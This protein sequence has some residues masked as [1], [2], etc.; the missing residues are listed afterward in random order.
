MADAEKKVEQGGWSAN[1][2]ESLKKENDTLKKQLEE[3]SKTLKTTQEELGKLKGNS[4]NSWTESGTK[5]GTESGTESSKEELKLDKLYKWGKKWVEKQDVQDTFNVIGEPHK[6][7][8]REFINGGKIKEL[9]QYLNWLVD[10]G[11]IDGSEFKSAC[12]PKWIWLDAKNH[13]SVDWKFWPQTLEALRMLKGK[14]TETPTTETPTTTET[15]EMNLDTMEDKYANVSSKLDFSKSSCFKDWALAEDGSLKYS[16]ETYKKV[17]SGD[18]S[19]EW[20]GYAVEKG[21]AGTKLVYVWVFKNGKLSE[22]I[23]VDSQGY[24]CIGKFDGNNVSW[25][26]TYPDSSKYKEY[27]WEYVF[28]KGPH[29]KWKLIYRSGEIVEWTF[30]EGKAKEGE[31]TSNKTQQWDIEMI[32]NEIK[33]EWDKDSSGNKID[34]NWIEK[35]KN[36]L[37]KVDFCTLK[38]KTFKEWG[39][40][41]QVIVGDDSRYDIGAYK[42]SNL[43]DDQADWNKNK[44]TRYVVLDMK[45]S[46]NWKGSVTSWWKTLN[47][48]ISN[49]QCLFRAWGRTLTFTDRNKAYDAASLIN[50]A[51][52]GTKHR[53]KKSNNGADSGAL[54][55]KFETDHSWIDIEFSNDGDDGTWI[56]SKAENYFWW[57]SQ[58]DIIKWMNAYLQ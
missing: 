1:D 31:S 43:V 14:G 44:W 35:N 45:D 13:I 23:R 25:K 15:S 52:F 55:S 42:K 58:D 28:G 12:E 38:W 30:E 49:G 24:R 9:Q 10:D 51:N 21:S 41:E 53:A 33:Y 32:G 36:N 18:S 17:E 27:I 19:Y 37:S 54:F 57:A 34:K 48:E 7:K 11:T 47:F 26:V 4:E 20:L 3:M 16:G 5:S 40:F 39:A 56:H 6:S 8:I 2:L 46:K 29:W 50:Y 22:W